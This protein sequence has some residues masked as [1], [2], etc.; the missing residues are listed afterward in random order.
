MYRHRTYREKSNDFDRMCLLVSRLNGLHLCDWSMGRLFEW[1][2]GRWSRESQTDCLFE[3]QAELFFD[4][5]DQLCG[6][7]ITENFGSSYY[8]LSF[9]DQALLQAMA[10]F[11]LRDEK[12]EKPY[13]ITVP[14]RDQ[15]Q[16]DVLEKAGLVRFGDA[17]VTYTYPACDVAVPAVTLPC[18][19]A[20]TSQKEYLDA[21][22]AERLR[23]YAFNPDSVYDAVIDRAYKYARQNPILVPELSILLLNE[24]GEP[25][26]TCMGL[27]DKENQFMEVEDVATKKEYENR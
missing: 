13:V 16:R 27:W 9:K 19:F 10:D 26:S 6:I 3:K 8:L 14:V 25:V 4:D 21:D 15:V 23:F 18:G 20:L 5:S 17:D 11:V 22:Q 2:Y 7:V 24:R 1:K 12:H